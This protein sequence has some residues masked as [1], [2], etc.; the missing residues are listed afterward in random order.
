M[1]YSG[2]YEEDLVLLEVERIKQE[3]SETDYIAL[4]S[5]EGYDCDTLYPG[6]KA[7]RKALRDRINELEASVWGDN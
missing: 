6:W 5:I 2:T 3:L 7:Q 4:K 1:A